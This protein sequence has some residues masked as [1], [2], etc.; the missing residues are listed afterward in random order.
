M[1]LLEGIAL[2]LSLLAILVIFGAELFRE[3][4]GPSG[5]LPAPM[6]FAFRIFLGIVFTILGVIGSLL[7]VM[8][9]WVFFLLAVFVLFPQSRFTIRL[10]DKAEHR[11]PRL[12]AWLRK[13]GIGVHRDSDT[14]AADDEEVRS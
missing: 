1:T 13:F 6:L 4:L 9:G 10:L 2:G 11:A 14:I 12:V 5:K 3:R 8:Q 7:P